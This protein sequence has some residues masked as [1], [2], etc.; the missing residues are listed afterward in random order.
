[1]H[2]RQMMSADTISSAFAP[3]EQLASQLIPNI[4]K[5]DDASH[6]ITH[7]LRVWK[8][9]RAIRATEGGDLTILVASILLHD[10]VSVEKNSPFRSQASRLAAEK[11]SK[12]L[13]QQGFSASTIDAVAHAIEAH[14]FSANVPPRTLEAKIVQDADRLDAIGM[15]GVARCFYVA[16]R[17]GRSLYEVGDPPGLSRRLDDTKFAV[18]HFHTKLLKLASGFQTEAGQTLARARHE[19]LT[20]YLNE[21]FDE[22]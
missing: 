18:D 5:V 6:D 4:Q 8:N 22:I 21:L 16:G 11:A 2:E 19:R 9:A 1:M 10:C 7:I 20:R 15:I 12:I 3:L 14:S 13:S 17:L